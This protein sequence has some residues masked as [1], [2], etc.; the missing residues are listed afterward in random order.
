MVLKY[1]K[2]N[3]GYYIYFTPR[4]L[5]I[6]QKENMLSCLNLDDVSLLYKDRAKFELCCIFSYMIAPSL[7]SKDKKYNPQLPKSRVA[8]FVDQ[9][10]RHSP[11]SVT[12]AS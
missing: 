11:S 8:L 5:S 7:N 2:S 10:I 3:N 12:I 6:S 9:P 1:R 4:F